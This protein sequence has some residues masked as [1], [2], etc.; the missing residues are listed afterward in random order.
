MTPEILLPIR[1]A[2]L[3]E[4]QLN[5][6][7]RFQLMKRQRY[8]VILS[9]VVLP[10]EERREYIG[11]SSLGTPPCALHYSLTGTEK[12]ETDV[13]S[14]FGFDT[15]HILEAYILDLLEIPAYSRQKDLVWPYPK[16]PG[17]KIAGHPDGVLEKLLPGGSCVVECKATGGYSFA[18]K[19]EEGPDQGHIEQTFCYAARLKSPL[20]ALIYANREAKK[21]TPFYQVFAYRILDQ[22][23]ADR[24]VQ[25]LFDIRFGQVLETLQTKRPTQ[26]KAPKFEFGA[27]GW[28]CRP[29]TSYF[30]QG[31][32]QKQVGYCS[33]RPV[34]PEAQGYLADLCRKEEEKKAA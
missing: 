25:T 7:L 12:E 8:G 16:A 24:A 3:A 20:F 11:V 34:C 9:Q 28:R 5:M 32:E 2:G 19:S 4:K 14:Q 1:R 15:G 6:V 21:S 29:D 33:Y 18:K 13:G 10:R 23:Q 31:R 30:A 22:G 17:G 26:P 27:R